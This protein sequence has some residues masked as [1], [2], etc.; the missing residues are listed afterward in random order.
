[1]GGDMYLIRGIVIGVIFGVP[2]GVIGIMTVQRTLEHGF[3]AGIATGFGSTAA[4]LLYGCIGVCGLTAVSDRLM[5][6]EWLIRLLGGALIAVFG[7]RTLR[8]GTLRAAAMEQNADSSETE[9]SGR[10]RS[11]FLFG[12][13]FLV[14]LTNPATILAF[15]TAFASSGLLG[16]VTAGQGACLLGGLALGTG[17]WWIFLAGITC[18][19]RRKINGGLFRTLNK[20]LGGLMVAFG[21]GAAAGG[22]L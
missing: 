15:L 22:I 20:V 13:S 16:G 8:A 7:V 5:S 14:A 3:A 11:L 21:I 10:R 2:A 12:S 1:M 17:G 6:W 4:D 18:V 19:L 9:V